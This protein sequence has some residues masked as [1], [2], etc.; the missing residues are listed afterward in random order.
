MTGAGDGR[1][2]PPDSHAEEHRIRRRDARQRRL[3]R[4][5]F[6]SSTR[7]LTRP[8][9]RPRTGTPL[10]PDAPRPQPTPHSPNNSG[11]PVVLPPVTF[12]DDEL[13]EW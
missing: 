4:E 9:L 13:Q 7:G 1:S 6:E 2:G 10:N 5:V 11:G 12:T 3:E 8:L